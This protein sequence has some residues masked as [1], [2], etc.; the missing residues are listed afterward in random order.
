MTA[1]HVQAWSLGGPADLITHPAMPLPTKQLFLF[2]SHV[3]L[4]PLALD[5]RPN[6][7][8]GPERRTRKGSLYHKAGRMSAARRL[9]AYFLP[10]PP[11]PPA[12][13]CLRRTTSPL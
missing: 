13:P 7:L 11:L 5:F 1:G 3:R 4:F 6:A 2:D 9:R 8:P 12:L 10:L